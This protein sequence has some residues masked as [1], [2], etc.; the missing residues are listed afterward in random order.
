MRKLYISVTTGSVFESLPNDNDSYFDL[1]TDAPQK[2]VYDVALGL[3]IVNDSV[4]KELRKRGF[5][6]SRAF[7]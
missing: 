5:N 1:K 4:I 6:A 3:E 7:S 2:E